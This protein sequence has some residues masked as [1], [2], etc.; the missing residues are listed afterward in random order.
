MRSRK[1]LYRG[2]GLRLVGCPYM[3]TLA[4]GKGWFYEGKM[5]DLSGRTIPGPGGSPT[6]SRGGFRRS[7][8]ELLGPP[9]WSKSYQNWRIW[10][11]LVGK[12]GARLTLNRPGRRAF[13]ETTREGA[14]ILEGT[15]QNWL[16][17]HENIKKSC[18]FVTNRGI[19][20][21]VLFGF[22]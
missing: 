13:R 18:R 8:G 17:S 21:G 5:K 12:I 9:E 11:F 2:R 3:S 16:F 10:R 6:G 14:A 19:T 4:S 1:K 15:V 22:R 7:S 20:K